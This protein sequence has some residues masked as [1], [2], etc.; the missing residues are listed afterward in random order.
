MSIQINELTSANVLVELDAATTGNVIGGLTIS[1]PTVAA[2]VVPSVN[3]IIS[4]FP[5]TFGPIAIGKAG[6]LNIAQQSGPSNAV[7]QQ[8]LA[9]GP[10]V[11]L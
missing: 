8:N 5:A 3:T 4:S 11:V 9:S 1:T 7:T 6:Q 10:I 2:P